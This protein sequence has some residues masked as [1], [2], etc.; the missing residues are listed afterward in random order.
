MRAQFGEFEKR[1]P[2][3]IRRRSREFGNELLVPYPEVL[4]AIDFANRQSIAVLGVEAFIPQQ[5][6]IQSESFSAYEFPICEWNVF[7]ALNNE[8]AK[9]YIA[10][11]P[12]RPAELV[13]I[14]TTASE[15]EYASLT[16]A[17]KELKRQ[18]RYARR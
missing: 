11:I 2:D 1:V 16:E 10:K 5:D 8:S 13:Y 9:E 12:S 7:V 4:E 14:L 3:N 15:R 18:G 17:A 6:G